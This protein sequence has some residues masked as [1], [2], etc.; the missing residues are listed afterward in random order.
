MTTSPRLLSL[1]PSGNVDILIANI[2]FR[3]TYRSSHAQLQ[4]QEF[5]KSIVGNNS[6]S[7]RIFWM[8]KLQDTRDCPLL[9]FDKNMAD[10][11]E[12]KN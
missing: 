2:A 7:C 1:E 9:S 12:F 10:D 4:R 6:S 5:R 11:E 3:S 8:A